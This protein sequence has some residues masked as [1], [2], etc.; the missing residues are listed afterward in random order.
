MR[1]T[2][3]SCRHN[4]N[5]FPSERHSRWHSSARLARRTLF[6]AAIEA[7]KEA[8]LNSMLMAETMQGQKN[9]TVHALPLARFVEIMSR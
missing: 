5:A 8:I 9:R 7:V 2:R 4:A 6:E 1:Q 3:L